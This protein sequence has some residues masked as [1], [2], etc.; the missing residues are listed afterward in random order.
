M[1]LATMMLVSSNHG[2]PRFGARIAEGSYNNPPEADDVILP[3]HVLC[4]FIKC[5]YY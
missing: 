1:T 4:N 5:V 3:I 2:L